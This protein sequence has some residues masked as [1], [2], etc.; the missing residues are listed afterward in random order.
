MTVDATTFQPVEAKAICKCDRFA[1]TWTF[2]C[3]SINK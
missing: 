2:L 3:H 1:A